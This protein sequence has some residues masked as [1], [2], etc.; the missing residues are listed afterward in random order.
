MNLSLLHQK[1]LRSA[2]F[3]NIFG[4]TQTLKAL[5]VTDDQ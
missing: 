5:I 3:E 2:S 4:T 1:Y